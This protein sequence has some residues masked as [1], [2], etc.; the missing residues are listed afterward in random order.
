MIRF[1]S[2]W[3]SLAT[4]A[5]QAALHALGEDEPSAR[6]LFDEIR[7]TVNEI[8]RLGF[9][10]QKSLERRLATAEVRSRHLE[11][12]QAHSN[13]AGTELSARCNLLNLELQELKTQNAGLR[14]ALS[15]RESTC[16]RLD[17]QLR[18]ELSAR[19]I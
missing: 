12:L 2:L 11:E 16:D 3:A 18:T 1:L 8:D 5:W 15:E 19:L 13:A 4:R 10:E 17:G 7:T 9:P 14:A 6:G